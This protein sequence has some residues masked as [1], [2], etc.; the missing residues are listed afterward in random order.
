MPRVS[1]KRRVKRTRKGR[2]SVRRNRRRTAMRGGAESGRCGGCRKGGD[3][4]CECLDLGQGTPDSVMFAE[5]EAEQIS[6]DFD[7][8]GNMAIPFLAEDMRGGGAIRKNQ[9]GGGRLRASKERRKAVEFIIGLLLEAVKT[10]R[11][12]WD[13]MADFFI[14]HLAPGGMPS[15]GHPIAVLIQWIKQF[16]G[17]PCLCVRQFIWFLIYYISFTNRWWAMPLAKGVGHGVKVAYENMGWIAGVVIVLSMIAGALAGAAGGAS[18]GYAGAQGAYNLSLGLL[19]F[20]FHAKVA[21]LTLSPANIIQFITGWAPGWLIANGIDTGLMMVVLKYIEDQMKLPVQQRKLLFRYEKLQP[22]L[23]TARKQLQ[24]MHDRA[25]ADA[26][27][28]APN[29]TCISDQLPPLLKSWHDGAINFL[30]QTTPISTAATDAAARAAGGAGADVAVQAG[31][32]AASHGRIVQLKAESDAA[33]ARAKEVAAAK[34]PPRQSTRKK[35]PS[36]STRGKSPRRSDRSRD[37][38]GSRGASSRD[39]SPALSPTSPTSRIAKKRVSKKKGKKSRRSKG[40]GKGKGKGR[41]S[42]RRKA[43]KQK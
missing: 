30:G 25:L 40:K 7:S 17:L 14:A 36:Q 23:E 13:A 42:K 41:N 29:T 28:W 37:S 34:R 18:A 6:G 24:D 2:R 8:E 12:C 27:W 35:L 4:T 20:A 33:G 15:D 38:T 39:A 3:K 10:G 1:R 32:A 19:S 16:I 11:F 21:M 26:N 5:I 31:A 43:R 22:L 9:S